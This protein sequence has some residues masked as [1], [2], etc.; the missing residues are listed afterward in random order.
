MIRVTRGGV[1]AA[2]L[3]R[4]LPRL[5]REF[6][7]RHFVRLPRILDPG[8]LRLVCS[9]IAEADFYE[10]SHAG[11]GLNRE[12]CLSATSP[13]TGLLHVLL[14]AP[15][16]FEL[17]RAVTRCDPIGC[18]VGRVYRVT[19]GGGH[20]DAWH[21]D[22]GDHRLVSM[23]VNL[24]TAAYVGGTLQMRARGSSEILCEAPNTGFGDA[25]LFRITDELEHRISDVEG[26]RSKTAFAG[27]FKSQPTFRALLARRFR[28]ARGR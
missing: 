24:S 13:A 20:H 19:P 17:V 11:I 4:S 9:Q 26:T 22:C 8:L 14:N 15:A 18:L 12:L 23:S 7:T 2:R 25:I 10:R 6:E 5:R 28:E 16:L 1:L 27:W 21:S 3:G